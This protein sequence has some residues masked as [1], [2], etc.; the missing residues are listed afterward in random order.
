MRSTPRRAAWPLRPERCPCDLDFVDYLRA[1]RITDKTIFHFGTG[2]H[3]VVGRANHRD[4]ANHVLAITA[5]PDEHA[6]YIELV[7]G[8]PEV[9]T[10]YQVL[11]ADIYCLDPDLLPALDVV[12]LF[13]LHEFYRPEHAAYARFDDRSLLAML[14]GRLRDEGRVLFYRG[15]DGFPATK[16]TIADAVDRALLRPLEQWGSLLVYGRPS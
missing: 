6:A 4:R 8:D 2:A 13:H 9:A 10:K 12:T 14:C 5:S 16:R 1:R 11:F 15:S 7:L 3:H